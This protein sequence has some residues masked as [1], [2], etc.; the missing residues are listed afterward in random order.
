PADPRRERVSAAGRRHRHR[1][2]HHLRPHQEYPEE[3]LARRECGGR[4]ARALHAPRGDL[5][6]HR[7]GGH[8]RGGA[9]R[10][11]E[12]LR[13]GGRRLPISSRVHGCSALHAARGGGGQPLPW[14]VARLL[15][16]RSARHPHLPVAGAGAEG[17]GPRVP[18]S[19]FDREAEPISL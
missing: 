6:D 17:L 19:R 1:G 13:H 18:L 12:E 7:G 14:V 4:A 3:A 11:A 8:H 2:G 9:L 10:Q 5:A 16:S 15:P